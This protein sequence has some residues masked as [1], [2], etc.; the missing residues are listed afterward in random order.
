MTIRQCLARATRALSEAGVPD[1]DYDAQEMLACVLGEDRLCMRID[2]GRELDDSVL[3]HYES[4]IGR[5]A[6]REPMQY[7]LGETCFMGL[8][9]H[10]APGVLIP[11][12]DT[13]ILCEEAIRRLGITGRRVLDI[14]TGSGALAIA[15]ALFGVEAQVTAVDV[16]D[17]ALTIAAEN[18]RRLGALVRFLKSDC[19]AQLPGEQ[20][21][22]IVSNPPYISAEEMRTLMPEVLHEPE[23]ALCG[24]EDGLDFYR[25]IAQEAPAHLARGGYLLFEIG[26]QQKEAVETLLRAHIGEPFALR[27]YGGNWRVVGARMGE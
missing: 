6:A 11:R 5:R 26:W 19:F 8:D 22:M 15:I 20:F 18:A 10:V 16:S 27:D 17:D 1:A 23:L 2:S 12:H 14:G 21:D 7:I 9:L 3:S 4:L 24:G 13:E 25:R